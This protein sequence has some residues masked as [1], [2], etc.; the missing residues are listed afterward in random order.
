[1]NQ[2]SQQLVSHYIADW[3]GTGALHRRVLIEDVYAEHAIH[4]DPT[5]ESSGREVIDAAIASV[6]GMFP[7]HRLALAGA[8]GAHHDT[9]RFIRHLTAPGAD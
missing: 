1:M 8:V 7:Q 6:R 3:N 4:L 9:M 2:T 5:V